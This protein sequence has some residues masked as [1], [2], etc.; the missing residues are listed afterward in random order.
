MVLVRE[1]I[2]GAEATRGLI[3][4]PRSEIESNSVYTIC[5][6]QNVYAYIRGFFSIGKFI[7]FPELKKKSC[8]PCKHGG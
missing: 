7:Y 1:R 3:P 6:K 4:G 5:H 2:A 8:I